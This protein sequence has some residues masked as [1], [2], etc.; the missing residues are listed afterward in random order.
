MTTTNNSN[1][2][3]NMD[4]PFNNGKSTRVG[5]QWTSNTTGK[6]YAPLRYRIINAKLLKNPEYQRKINAS[7]VQKII[8]NFRSELVRPIKVGIDTDGKYNI[9]DGQHTYV[10]LTT[11]FGDDIDVACIIADI[12]SDDWKELT[13]EE[14][15]A[16]MFAHQHDNTK[17]VSVNDQFAASVIGR[18]PYA[19]DI[20]D[21]CKE[22]GFSLN[23]SN[24]PTASKDTLA[25]AGKIKN[26]YMIDNGHLLKYTL[27]VL[28]E[29]YDGEVDSLDSQFIDIVAKFINTF[30]NEDNF[31]YKRLVKAMSRSIKY[32]KKFMNDN[33][34]ESSLSRNKY[35]RKLSVEN[36]GIENMLTAYNKGL[37]FENRLFS[38]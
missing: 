21:I 37:S 35:G 16:R 2:S 8:N 7:N 36:I 1:S 12:T 24:G 14:A 4:K 38:K 22:N 15:E 32:P 28:R 31:N 23:Y 20:L 11:M 26:L 19:L 34:Y 17:K 3:N 5:N 29:V 9:I 25:C 6:V 10:A 13:S 18:E 27:A 33:K 30:E